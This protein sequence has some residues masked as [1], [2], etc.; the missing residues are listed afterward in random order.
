MNC[1]KMTGSFREKRDTRRKRSGCT[2][3]AETSRAS[4]YL[5]PYLRRRRA[6]ARYGPYESIMR[7]LGRINDTAGREEGQGEEE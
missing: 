1:R 4:I 6:L 7:A 5:L 2:R 3:G